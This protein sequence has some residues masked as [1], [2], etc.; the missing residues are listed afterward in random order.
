MNQLKDD[1]QVMQILWSVTNWRSYDNKKY[2]IES[3]S[4]YIREFKFNKPQ[5]RKKAKETALKL[6][7]YSSIRRV[8]L[9]TV[10]GGIV[11]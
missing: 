8:K 4:N 7:G 6:E 2:D 10:T 5:N 9:I 3:R 1:I 11:N